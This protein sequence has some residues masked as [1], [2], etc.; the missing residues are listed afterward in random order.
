MHKKHAVLSLGDSIRLGLASRSS[1]EE[2]NYQ[3]TPFGHMLQASDGPLCRCGLQGCI[4]TYAEFC[5]ILRCA[6]DAPADR[7]PTQ[8][9]PKEQMDQ[10]AMK[11]RDGDRMIRF[12]F[13]QAADVMAM[14]LSRLMTSH[15]PID[16][17]DCPRS[18]R[19]L[20]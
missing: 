11:A 2:T 13:R 8:F 20:F 5:G 10:L 15:G 14:G 1:A 4:E 9:I 18:W 16:V 6:F 19:G 12:A 7:I 3:A 17:G